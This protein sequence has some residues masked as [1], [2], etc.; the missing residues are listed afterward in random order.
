MIEPPEDRR[1][2][3]TPQLALRVAMVG[4]LA[5]TLFAIIF[6]R[7]WFLQILTGQQ[8]VKAATVNRTR[9]ISIAAARGS[10]LDRGGKVLVDSSQ[11]LAVEISPT[12][13][14]VPVSLADVA[15]LERPPARDA[16]VYNRLARLLG[17]PTGRENCRLHVRGHN[18]FRLSRVACAVGQQLTL[19][20]YADV[21]IEQGPQVSSDVQYYIAERQNQFPGVT[22]A[23]V[24]V[25]HYPSKTLAAQVLGTV[26]RITAG[27][28]KQRA[29]RGVAPDSVIGQSGV[30]AQY[31]SFLQGRDGQEKVQINALGEPTA[32]LRTVQPRAGHDL[33]LSLDARLQQVG[34]QAL[35]QSISQNAG[36]GG[37]F[38]AM[39]P[40]NGEV[41]AMGSS[42]TFDPSIF[43]RP[44]SQKAYNEL[45][46]TTA[47][48]PLLNRA[49]GSVGPTGST[50]KPITAVA[51]LQSGAWSTGDVFDDTG[52]FC[53][54]SGGATQCRH[55]AGKAVFGSVD[56]INAIRVS[57]D[58]F[59]YHLGALLNPNDP[60]KHPD[61]GTLG[62]WAHQFGIGRSTDID[63]PGASSGTLPTPAWRLE[64]NR[65]EAECDHATGAY[66][67]SN[68]SGTAISSK[69]K[70]GFHRSPTHP[71]GGCGIA[72]G[73]NRPWSIGDN[74]SLAVGQGDVQAS[75]LQL[76]IVYSALENGGTIVRPHL[77]LS[78]QD[79]AGTVLQTIN[80][81]PSRHISIN[82]DYL[83]TIQAGL[84]AAASQAGGTSA[85]VMGSLH[86]PVY[87]KTG[88]AQYTGQPDTAWYACFVPMG[89]KSIVVVV[90]VEKGG[91]GDTAAAPVARQILS[92]WFFN[93]PG[94][95][96]SGTS[97]TL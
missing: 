72:D 65:L 42:P 86:L 56:L 29:Y 79:N 2:P 87:G 7:L 38:V 59:F 35:S 68:A 49:I 26:G 50:F 34:E 9:G 36:S 31:N 32:K 74:E 52:S 44:I 70:P 69:R 17:M 13:L 62:E 22:V 47:G 64:R 12:D 37:S 39:N 45:N 76:A 83:A 46:S 97:K 53:V 3:L 91:F 75:P 95:Y 14:P 6:F 15:T 90:H 61:G 96:V 66:R 4:S 27:Q 40:D 57:S 28:T 92:Q 51:A 41:Y 5:L 89:K 16:A 11:A 8:Y 82:S 85:D 54:G 58:D 20:A 30:E 21:Q 71:A 81:P 25:T 93:K 10:I 63:L 23:K 67:Y 48:Q 80:P 1:P 60:A 33:K 55:N 73:T 18:V 43:T 94:P 78:V 77:G 24:D 19:V 84:R 88:T